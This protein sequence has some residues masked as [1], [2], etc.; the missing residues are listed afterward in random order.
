MTRV[1]AANEESNRVLWEGCDEIQW[2][3][4]VRRNEPEQCG[5][6]RA[7]A[8]CEARPHQARAA[9]A[10]KPSSNASSA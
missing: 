4:G 9:A 7:G 1:S 2:R 5:K 3:T 10:A 6:R 8:P